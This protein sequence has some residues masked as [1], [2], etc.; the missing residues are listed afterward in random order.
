MR[1]L[2][3]KL[4]KAEKENAE[5]SSKYEVYIT[6]V[7]KINNTLQ[8]QE[9]RKKERLYTITSTQLEDLNKKYKALHGEHQQLQQQITAERTA[10]SKKDADAFHLREEL[11][12]LQF[13][14]RT[15]RE[16]R[17]RILSVR[18]ALLIA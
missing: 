4:K 11:S 7:V 13:S 5:L 9:L 16:E 6:G 8:W 10:A 14:E 17:S 18:T 15:L 12:A 2:R 3:S 1:V